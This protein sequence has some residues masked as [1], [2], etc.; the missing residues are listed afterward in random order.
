M[1]VDGSEQTN[2]T[3]NPAQD[4]DPDWSPDGRI[5]FTS[6]RDGAVELYTID[7]D[8]ANLRQLTDTSG[9][10]LSA[11]WSPD[12]QQIAYSRDGSITV[13]RA[14]A[15]NVRV[16][17]EA[18]AESTAEP[19]HAAGFLGDWSPDGQQIVFYS[20]SASRNMAWLC[21][22]NVD[23]SGLTV[24]RDAPE[25]WHV[26]PVF[27]PDGTKVAYRRIRGDD[28]EIMVIDLETGVEV[29]LTNDPAL[30]LEPA[31]SPD[32]NWIAFASLRERSP[33]FDIYIMRPDGSD[34]RRLTDDPAKDSFPAWSP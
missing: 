8:A 24:L 34:L 2:L 25:T 32:G 11:K 23:G 21:T 15:A 7:A 22:I 3:N 31:W 10:E 14:D 20:A 1:N 9:G 29:N 12:G 13:M 16:L 28:Y 26:E 17:I 27:S 5:V 30:D 33:H 19:C 18:Q 6:N 4:F